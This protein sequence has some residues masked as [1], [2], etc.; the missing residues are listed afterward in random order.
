MQPPA[1]RSRYAHQVPRE[2][3]YSVANPTSNEVCLLGQLDGWE[4][5]L[6]RVSSVGVSG[7]QPQAPASQRP[8]ASA[9][10]YHFIPSVSPSLELNA[11]NFPQDFPSSSAS[12]HSS[13]LSKVG[14]EFSTQNP[15]S[16]IRRHRQPSWHSQHISPSAADPDRAETR[17]VDIR[18]LLDDSQYMTTQFLH[19]PDGSKSEAGSSSADF[20]PCP[21]H[22]PISVYPSHFFSADLVGSISY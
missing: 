6:R 1:R 8:S 16:E 19:P 14:S 10:D 7:T 4:L 22:H 2:P 21:S 13:P 11:Q 5:V 12:D 15:V 9:W 20:V 18:S 17:S 3:P